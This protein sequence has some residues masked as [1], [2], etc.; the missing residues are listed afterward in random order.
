MQNSNNT[1]KKKRRGEKNEGL[2]KQFL[3]TDKDDN[4]LHQKKDIK[5]EKKLKKL[6]LL[7]NVFFKKIKIST[8]E[9][10]K[11]LKMYDNNVTPPPK[12]HQHL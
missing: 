3:V 10:K 1:W 7:R 5:K 11:V 2:K 4:S 9:K 8:R 12:S 6:K